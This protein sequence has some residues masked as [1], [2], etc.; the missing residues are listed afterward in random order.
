MNTITLGQWGEKAACRYLIKKGL[1]ILETNYR[2][3][4][5]EI[6]IIGRDKEFLVFIE[7]KTRRS[8]SYGLPME[9]IHYNK[10]KKYAKIALYFIKGKKL[11]DMNYRFDI[12]EVY[13]TNNRTDKINHLPNAFQPGA[14][15]LFY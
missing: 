2:C 14:S 6:D 8:T 7:V 10:Q 11:F 5:G 12:V 1:T 15:S 4:A 13:V 9:S 3:P